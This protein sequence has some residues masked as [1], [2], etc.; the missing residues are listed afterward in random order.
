MSPWPLHSLQL[1][2]H[3][4]NCPPLVWL[5]FAGPCLGVQVEA[6]HTHHQ[7]W[8]ASLAASYR[9]CHSG[10]EVRGHRVVQDPRGLPWHP[11]EVGEAGHSDSHV[12]RAPGGSW[13]VLEAAGRH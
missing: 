2:V 8:Q 1:P 7:L 11:M 3:M 6:D 12:S 9:E 13:L 4:G 10:Q 5:L